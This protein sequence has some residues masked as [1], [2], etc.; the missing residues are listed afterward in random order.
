VNLSVL[1]DHLPG[2]PGGMRRVVLGGEDPEGARAHVREGDLV[3]ARQDLGGGQVGLPD[4][5]RV[6]RPLLARDLR[7]R[8]GLE[9][10]GPGLPHEQCQQYGS[11]AYRTILHSHGA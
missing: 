4:L 7:G 2:D 5:L 1:L 11:Q 10:L 8:I 3:L 6:L 9:F